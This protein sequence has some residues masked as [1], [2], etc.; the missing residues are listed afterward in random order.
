MISV[1]KSYKDSLGNLWKCTARGI[2]LKKERF[3]FFISQSGLVWF[4]TEH[5]WNLLNEK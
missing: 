4:T 1:G 3:A 5:D 2:T